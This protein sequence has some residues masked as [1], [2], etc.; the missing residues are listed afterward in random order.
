[1]T[2]GTKNQGTAVALMLA[3]VHGAIDG[4]VGVRERSITN[5]Q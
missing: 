1:M 3:M 4:F 5:A 2:L